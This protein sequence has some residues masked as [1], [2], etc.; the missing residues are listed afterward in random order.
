MTIIIYQ[1]VFEGDYE[2]ARYRCFFHKQRGP[3]CQESSPRCIGYP[4]GFFESEYRGGG[5][6]YKICLNGRVIEVGKCPFND[7]WNTPTFIYKR[8]CV[9]VYEIPVNEHKYGHLPSCIGKIDGSYQYPQE[10]YKCNAYFTCKNGTARGIKC[11]GTQLFDV[12]AGFCRE[13]AICR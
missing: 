7:T 12:N 6:F 3:S 9:S 1:F 10:K 8:R 5:P 11:P 4:D 2:R 13:G